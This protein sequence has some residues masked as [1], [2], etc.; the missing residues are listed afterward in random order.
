MRTLSSLHLFAT[1]LILAA[2]PGCTGLR[3][4]PSLIYLNADTNSYSRPS[5]I[6]E[7]IGHDSSPPAS[8]AYFGW[9]HGPASMTPAPSEYQTASSQVTPNHATVNSQP[10]GVRESLRP[11]SE[12]GSV[13]R[14]IAPAPPAAPIEIIVPPELAPPPVQ[15]PRQ[16]PL[17]GAPAETESRQ[18]LPFDAPSASIQR[19]TVVQPAGYGRPS[20]PS[21]RVLFARP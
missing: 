4:F 10:M 15:F 5:L 6:F 19:S 16:V 9:L 1:L 7:R 13:E 20:L 21:S 3:G 17:P 18:E 11:M 12:P 2:L 8:T 14:P